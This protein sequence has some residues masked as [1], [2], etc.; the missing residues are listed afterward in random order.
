[1][2]L[3]RRG[4][5]VLAPQYKHILDRHAHVA[6]CGTGS[7][8]DSAPAANGKSPPAASAAADRFFHR[9][10][11]S[12]R[13][14][15]VD[16]THMLRAVVQAAAKTLPRPH[17][18]LGERASVAASRPPAR[19]IASGGEGGGARPRAADEQLVGGG[20]G[21]CVL[22]SRKEGVCGV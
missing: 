9:P 20:E 22:P 4:V 8:Q 14:V 3:A 10:P 21:V 2:R 12:R 1:M 18:H 11:L 13:C 16:A 5:A 6:G 17:A 15:G 19:A 7:R